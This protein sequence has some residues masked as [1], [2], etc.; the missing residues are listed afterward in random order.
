[1][2]N[3]THRLYPPAQS[4]RGAT[5][6]AQIE[7]PVE[8]NGTLFA[9][10]AVA[11]KLPNIDAARIYLTRRLAGSRIYWLYAGGHHVAV[12][13]FFHKHRLAIVAEV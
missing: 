11:S 13:S 3:T 1:M 4:T 10:L 2:T 7:R 6:T 9:A 5:L 8:V 12:Q